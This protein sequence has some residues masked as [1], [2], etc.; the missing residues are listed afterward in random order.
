MMPF[1]R[2]GSSNFGSALLAC[3]TKKRLV[4]RNATYAPVAAE[5]SSHT[6]N[7]NITNNI[8]TDSNSN[9]TT[10]IDGNHNDG[11]NGIGHSHND[12]RQ[13]QWQQHQHYTY[14]QK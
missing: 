6:S 4:R 1:A 3:I 2:T 9:F 5:N 7:N 11:R 14:Q 10:K 12:Q 13:Q 8:N